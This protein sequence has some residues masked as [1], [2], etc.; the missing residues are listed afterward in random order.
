MNIIKIIPDGHMEIKHVTDISNYL[1]EFINDDID[2]ILRSWEQ[3]LNL[4]NLNK[5]VF[6]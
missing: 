1:K 4:Q 6:I 2:L 5:F 3:R